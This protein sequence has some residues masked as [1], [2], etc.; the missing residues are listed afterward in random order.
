MCLLGRLLH[1]PPSSSPP[2]RWGAGGAEGRCGGEGGGRQLPYNSSCNDNQVVRWP[3]SS[4]G[5]GV[6][7]MAPMNRC[8]WKRRRRGGRGGRGGDGG[9]RWRGLTPT[10]RDRHKTSVC[11]CKNAPGRNRHTCMD[12]HTH[13]QEKKWKWSFKITVFL[14]NVD[15]L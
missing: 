15:S 10:A 5:A 14:L 9:K 11:T 12:T 3:G 4:V 7:H 13:T 2:S 8:S 6:T 1:L